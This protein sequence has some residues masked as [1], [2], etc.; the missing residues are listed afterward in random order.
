MRQ[1]SRPLCSRGAESASNGEMGAGIAPHI[2]QI[3]EVW[4]EIEGGIGCF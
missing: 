1:T 4:I 3:A 2:A